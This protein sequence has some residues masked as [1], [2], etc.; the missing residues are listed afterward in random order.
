MS[1]LVRKI[2]KIGLI[3]VLLFTVLP[4][5]VTGL[6]SDMQTSLDASL[7]IVDETHSVF[8][9]M[10]AKNSNFSP[11]LTIWADSS[12]YAVMQQIAADFMASHN[13]NVIVEEVE[14]IYNEFIL[15]A[16]AGTGPDITISSH[17]QMGYLHSMGLLGSIDLSPIEENFSPTALD[18]VKFAGVDYGLPYAVEN[19]AFIYNTDLVPTPPATW[20]AMHTMGQA[21][22]TAGDVTWGFVFSGTTYDVYPLMTAHGGYVFGRNPDGSWDT[23]DL[24]ID[25]TGMIAFGDT[26]NIWA[27]EGFLLTYIDHNNAH[28]LFENGEVPW[29][30][31][32]PWAL[33]RIRQSGINYE[34]SSFPSGI[35]FSGV[36]A[37]VI[38]A[39]SNE[40][41]LAEYFLTE[42]LATTEVMLQ[43]Y[44]NGLRPPA[45][46][47]A[48]DLI[49]DPDIVAF[50]NA[51]LNAEPMPNI[52]EMGCVWSYWGE[53]LNNILSGEKT[54]TEAYTEAAAAIRNCIDNPL[55]GM[56]N[57]PGS[58]QSEVGCSGDWDPACSATALTE[59]TDGLF[60]GDFLIPAGNWECKVALDGSWNENYGVGGIRDGENYQFTTPNETYVTF[61]YH[62]DTHILDIIILDTVNVPGS[63][64]SEVGCPSDWDPACTTTYLAKGTDNLYS[65]EFSIPAG[66]YECKVAINN[67]WDVNYGVG[68]QPNGPNYEFTVPAGVL[69]TFVYHPDTHV[70]DIVT[71]D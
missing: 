8:L 46:L 19:L 10:I 30:M 56:V 34:I 67:T 38:N 25:S 44:D 5:R 28:T 45:Y 29:I 39:F 37:F 11:I 60:R 20:E 41:A 7:D 64:Q 55:T 27:D 31:A 14:D 23:N 24:G 47:P 53:A 50:G 52:P 33:G 70:L 4:G 71:S 61:V 43:L 18:A 26:A 51:G 48:L 15:A 2:F 36:Q 59:G 68:G 35:P 16:P 13:V 54:S 21:L 22:Q 3:F 42:Y 17:D 65:G 12:R 66:N 32:G 57:V 6:S 58:Y 40:K 9:P 49:A 1:I 63:F 62:P 69:V